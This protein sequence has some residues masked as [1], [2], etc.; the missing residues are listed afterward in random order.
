[1]CF[2]QSDFKAGS[3]D[4]LLGIIDDCPF[5]IGGAQHK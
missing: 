5:Y 4:A 3:H 2:S 1:M